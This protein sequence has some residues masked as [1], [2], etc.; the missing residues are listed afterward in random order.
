MS[1]D[2][3][4]RRT[5]RA[6]RPIT[7]RRALSRLSHA[8]A[9]NPQEIFQTLTDVAVEACDADSAGISILEKGEDGLRFRWRAISGRYAQHLGGMTPRDFSPCGTT[10]DRNSPQLVCQPGR[11]FSYFNEVDPPI[12][13]GLLVPFSLGDKPVGTVWIVAHDDR[14]KFDLEDTRILTTLASFAAAGYELISALEQ[15]TSGASVRGI[16]ISAPATSDPLLPGEPTHDA[17]PA[18][19][20]LSGR[21]SEVMG[22]MVRGVTQK[23]IGLALGISVKTVATH[24]A[25]VLKKLN[26][27]GSFDL[28]RYALQNHL[29]A[30]SEVH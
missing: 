21:E 18:D 5:P 16:S 20:D 6:S 8:L 13:E 23:Q 27:T 19:K 15:K 17:K 24:R 3:L 26:L 29:V 10:I 11:Y 4:Y 28:L 30:W 14:R 1:T 12:C 22:M 2:L 9:E 25:R 7:E